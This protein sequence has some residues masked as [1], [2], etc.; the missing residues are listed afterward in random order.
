MLG[1]VAP[2]L[3]VPP[4]FP[5]KVTVLPAQNVVA[6]PAVMVDAVGVALTITFMVLELTLPQELL[7]VTK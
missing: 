2:L 6:P 7:F 3:Q 1:V 5:V 4:T